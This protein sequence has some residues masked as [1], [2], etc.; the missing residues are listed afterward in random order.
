MLDPV[1]NREKRPEARTF[2]HLPQHIVLVN[3]KKQYI[4]YKYIFFSLRLQ[5]K[6]TRQFTV[7]KP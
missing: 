5:M 2:L 4:E 1:I 7:P 3:K 6:G